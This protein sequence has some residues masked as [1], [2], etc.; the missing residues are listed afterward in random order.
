[1]LAK[2]CQFPI[3][4]NNF[5]RENYKK[6]LNDAYF[7]AIMEA[8]SFTITGYAFQA[9]LLWNHPALSGVLKI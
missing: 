1:L 3:L 8:T 2:F 5:L 6:A 4:A 9:S 7:F